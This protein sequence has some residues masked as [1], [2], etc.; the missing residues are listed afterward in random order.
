M[1][2]S[3][4]AIYASDRGRFMPM[5]GGD[6]CQRQGAMYANDR[7]RFIQA[8]RTATGRTARFIRPHNDGGLATSRYSV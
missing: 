8:T 4:W 5:T 7:V 2:A 6:V 1:Y 3:D